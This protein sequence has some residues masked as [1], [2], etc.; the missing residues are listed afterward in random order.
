MITNYLLRPYD[1]LFV[2]D[3]RPMSLEDDTAASGLFPPPPSVFFGA[4]RSAVLSKANAN[5]G[6]KEDPIY[7]GH[8][9]GLRSLIKT[10]CYFLRLTT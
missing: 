4:L 6:S 10:N 9:Q 5:P 2:K 1:K 8:I 7:T 3:G